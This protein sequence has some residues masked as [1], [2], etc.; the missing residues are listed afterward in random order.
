[1]GEELFS[2]FLSGLNEE[3]PVTIRVNPLKCYHMP[4]D[5][6]CRVSWCN[7]GFYLNARPPFTFDPLMHAGLYYVQE[8]SSMFVHEV[9]RQLVSEP[10]LMLDLCAAPGG[11]STAVRT[12]LPNGS[13]LVCNEPV[14]QRAQVLAENLQKFGHRDVIVTNNLP[15]DF[16]QSGLLFDA[17]L[18]D[19]PCS[20]EGM[21]RKDPGAIEEWSEQHVEKCWQ[22]QR[23]IVRDIWPQLRNGG[24]MIYST[25][26]FNTKENEENVRWI[27]EELGAEPVAVETK[28][29]WNITGSLLPGFNAPVYRFIPGRSRGEGLFVAIMRKN[30]S[31]PLQ[32]PDRQQ[33]QEKPKSRKA[34]K[35]Q[36]GKAAA[37][38][39]DR[40]SWWKEAKGPVLNGDFTMLQDGNKFAAIPQTPLMASTYAAARR[41]LN[42]LHAG[43]TLGVEKGHDVIPHVSL[44]LAGAFRKEAFPRVALTH[45]EAIR[46]LRGEVMV[47]PDSVPRGFVVVT[48]MDA[49]L[50]F[51][52]NIGSR[53]NNLY[54]QEW[55]IKSTHIPTEAPRV[56][57]IDYTYI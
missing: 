34:Q 48:Y 2:Q 45:A 5:Y 28:P 22:L 40:P 21:F 46:Y 44:A 54:P 47:L 9:L 8:A 26:T 38:Q 29:E 35:K 1:M 30:G 24:L 3:P 37:T 23:E 17:V 27:C 36:A 42:L 41:H 52:K 43:V 4:L 50:G 16:Q 56:L 55:R 11:K 12:Q 6:E 57:D 14:R 7:A 25:C 53:A 13:V 10:V 15:R 19:V 31:A 18:A 51:V 49:C 20:G 39:Q 33:G 32:A